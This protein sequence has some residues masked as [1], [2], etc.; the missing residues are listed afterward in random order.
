MG[1]VIVWFRQ[2]LRVKDHPALAAASGS[3][4]PVMPLYIWAP[5]EEEGW[6]PGAAG[7][8]WLHHAMKDLDAEL[9]R[10]GSR[11][12]TRSGDTLAIL[13]EMVEK[14]RVDRVMWNRRY[15]PAA[16]ARDEYIFE[17]LTAN[18]I[19]CEVFNGSLLFDPTLIR[20]RSGGSFTVFTPFWNACLDRKESVAPVAAFKKLTKPKHWPKSVKVDELKLLPERRWADG[21]AASWQ[22]T[23]RAALSRLKRFLPKL[24]HYPEERD[25]PDLLGTS[26]LSPYLH[27]GQ[28]SPRQI[29]HT[30]NA[31]AE[32]SHQ[33]GVIAGASAFLRQLGWREF[34]YHI[35]THFSHTPRQPL[36]NRGPR[37]PW[38]H[39]P[40]LLRAWQRGTTGYPLVDAGMRELW[41]TGW[42]HNRV[43]MV[44]ASFLVKHLMIDWQTG[45]QWFWDTLVDADLA[46]NTLGWQ[47]AAGCGADA[48]PYFRVFNPW[49]QQ[50]KF[51]PQ[52]GYVGRFVP[53][54][55]SSNRGQ[56]TYPPPIVDH[57]AARRRFLSSVRR[58][59]G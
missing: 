56:G 9:H 18:G 23:E 22:P 55:A 30:V 44:V 34:A 31:Y 38:T 45:A 36:R 19:R 29:W 24:Q 3:G 59:R 53:E 13:R 25:R 58:S 54:H 43:R 46:N 49:L 32:R 26:R 15:E 12:I 40:A 1:A 42:M 35:L 7:L 8:W 4:A 27:W 47:W 11:L 20:T 14:M 16:M 41:Q 51:D 5:D 48:V 33:A 52:G 39:D 6:A 57:V 21:I 10:Y 28:I 37:I 50:R 2:D 17:Q